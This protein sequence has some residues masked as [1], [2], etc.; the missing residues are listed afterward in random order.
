MG[1]DRQLHLS[2][3]KGVHNGVPASIGAAMSS[4]SQVTVISLHGIRTRGAWQK[5]LTHVLNEA[6]FVHRPLEFG[7]FRAVSL[8][9][10]W[11][12][13]QKVEWFRDEYSYI[14]ETSR[15]PVS[16]IAHS[17]GSY[18]VAT[19][20]STYREIEF[21]RIILCGSIVPV[22][23]DWDALILKRGQANEVLNQYGKRDIWVR[24]AQW[25]IA[26][27]GP[28]GYDGFRRTA[29]GKVQQQRFKSYSHSQYFH[30]LNFRK[31]WIPFLQG[32]G[33]QENFDLQSEGVNWRFRLLL[34]VILAGLVIA[35][36]VGYAAYQKMQDPAPTHLP[37]DGTAD[38]S[39]VENATI[40]TSQ[41]ATLANPDAP[42][43]QQ[44]TGASTK[45]T[46]REKPPSKMV[47]PQRSARPVAESSAPPPATSSPATPLIPD[48]EVQ[49]ISTPSPVYPKGSTAEGTTILIVDV[50]AEGRVFNVHVLRSSMDRD[51]DSAA[52]QAVRTWRFRPAI[53]NG[54]AVQSRARIPVAF[55]LSE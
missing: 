36:Y 48:A 31:N 16:I 24:A 18:L 19:A 6:G 25:A 27:A 40:Q 33:V 2:A 5:S 46:T 39:S 32:R 22:R 42:Q 43:H 53:K 14:K 30:S 21:E 17:F 15:G 35:A 44:N 45:P 8:I 37:L 1:A 54:K 9:N 3:A 34:F 7:F 13:S 11:A 23:F 51:L 28:S 4:E 52:V 12:R 41:P 10:P 38:I 20:M 55:T 47:V 29:G 50:D 49:A 26:D